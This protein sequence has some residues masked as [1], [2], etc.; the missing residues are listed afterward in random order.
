MNKLTSLLP[1]L[2]LSALGCH[3]KDPVAKPEPA[4]A[5]PASSCA[6]SAGQNLGG[7]LSRSARLVPES[8]DGQLVGLR[9]YSVKPDGPIARAGFRNA[10]LVV[11]VND[12]PVSWSFF[13]EKGPKIKLTVDREHQPLNIDCTANN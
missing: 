4:V 2:M 6:L 12:R 11:A 3:K 1:L 8:R 10:D 5:A 9:L 13:A 7:F